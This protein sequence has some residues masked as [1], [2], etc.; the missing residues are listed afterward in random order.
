MTTE[1]LRNHNGR[2]S[3]KA[4]DLTP[5]ENM[6]L[7]LHITFALLIVVLCGCDPVRTIK[8]SVKVKVTSPTGIPIQNINVEAGTTDE[9]IQGDETPTQLV[10]KAAGTTNE[11]GTAILEFTT[12]MIDRSTGSEPSYGP[13]RSKRFLLTVKNGSE[14]LMIEILE[15]QIQE[16]ESVRIEV[17][18]VSSPRYA[19]PGE[20]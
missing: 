5:K 19:S 20:N 14:P 1:D 11:F 8:Q 18:E 12:T 2:R 13:A 6:N 17:M 3:K 4:T 16:N 15:G 7:K 9:Q 10:L